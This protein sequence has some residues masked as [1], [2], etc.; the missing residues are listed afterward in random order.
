LIDPRSLAGLFQECYHDA[1]E[2]VDLQ[3]FSLI[4]GLVAWKVWR[5]QS[6]WK[7]RE[8]PRPKGRVHVSYEGVEKIIYRA[9]R[10][11]IIRSFQ[12]QAESV[13]TDH[14]IGEVLRQV[15]RN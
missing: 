7:M 14:V 13:S 8:L 3:W 15:W 11:R 9:L 12:A 10:H 2:T 1:V 6:D 5:R 4:P